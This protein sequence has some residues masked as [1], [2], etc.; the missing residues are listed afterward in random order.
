MS[1]STTQ[2]GLGLLA[3]LQTLVPGSLKYVGQTRAPIGPKNPPDLE[4]LGAPTAALVFFEGEE[5]V[6]PATVRTLA[7]GV[8]QRIGR[9][10]WIVSIA[11]EDSRDAAAETQGAPST[12]GLW[13]LI[14]AVEEV[15]NG[16]QVAAPPA[17]LQLRVTGTP[18]ATAIFGASVLQYGP[19][20]YKPNGTNV[21]LN[22]AGEGTITATLSTLD[23]LGN[24]PN[25][26]PLSWSSTPANLDATATVTATQTQGERGHYRVS[27]F[28][29]VSKRHNFSFPGVMA[30]YDLRLTADRALAA[31]SVVQESATFET[32]SADLND[33]GDSE[34]AE[35]TPDPTNPRQNPRD[36][37][38]TPIP[39]S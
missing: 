19:L 3:A 30:V 31:R 38:T 10:S 14:N 27:S 39:T 22:G 21:V 20:S 13:S 15:L 6:E 24:V 32:L 12:P 36:S 16:L 7:R 1:A 17:T 5:R 9:S 29:L 11:V 34:N 23:A 33:E 35:T 26:A 8:T 18:N 25:G 28:E 4:S 2:L 37:I